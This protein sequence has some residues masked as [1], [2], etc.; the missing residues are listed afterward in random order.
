MQSYTVTYDTNG[1]SENIESETIEKTYTTLIID[2]IPTRKGY[3][4]LGW[5]TSPDSEVAEYHPQTEILMK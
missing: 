1:G 5:A 4:F 2:T 3:K